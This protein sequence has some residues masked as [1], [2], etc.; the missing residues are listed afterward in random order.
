MFCLS[1]LIFYNIHSVSRLQIS[2]V[3][4]PLCKLA[5]HKNEHSY[6]VCTSISEVVLLS[7]SIYI[8]K[9]QQRQQQQ[10]Q[11]NNKAKTLKISTKFRGWVFWKYETVY[12]KLPL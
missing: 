1:L 6:V 7:Y 11:S 4:I 9:Q 12:T 8:I 2:L 3:L 5:L 10:Q